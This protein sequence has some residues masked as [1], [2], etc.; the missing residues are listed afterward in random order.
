MLNATSPSTRDAI[1][2]LRIFTSF[3]E[4]RFLGFHQF[5]PLRQLGQKRVNRLPH[6]VR[7]II[8]HMKNRA[9][10]IASHDHTGYQCAS[11]HFFPPFRLV[12]LGEDGVSTQSQ[13]PIPGC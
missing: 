7:K 13:T 12:T 5:T 2:A 8:F 10:Q 6:L 9:A 11:C 1:L 3:R 4:L